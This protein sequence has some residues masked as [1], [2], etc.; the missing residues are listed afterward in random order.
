MI[1]LFIVGSQVNWYTN[2]EQKKNVLLFVSLDCYGSRY[3]IKTHSPHVFI[4]RYN[5]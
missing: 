3:F 1:L 2:R 4:S 5:L